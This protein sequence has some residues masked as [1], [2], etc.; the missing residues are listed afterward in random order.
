MSVY[1]AAIFAVLSS[2]LCVMLKKEKAEFS[3]L[4]QLSSA[5]VIV[6]SCLSVVLQIRSTFSGLALRGGIDVG[7]LALLFRA[8]CMCAVTEWAAAFCR[9]AG[10]TALSV[11]VEVASKVWLFSMCLP[12][13]ETVFQFAMG[14]FI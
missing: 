10:L 3:Q 14:F 4:V 1:K 8:V 13:V 7:M 11:T 5:V 2:M 6:F 12:L 9:D